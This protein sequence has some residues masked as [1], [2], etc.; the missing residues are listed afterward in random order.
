MLL[1]S[2][3]QKEI[4]T[5]HP[6]K[7]VEKMN[8]GE[9]LRSIDIKV[10]Q[11]LQKKDLASLVPLVLEYNSLA[12]KLDPRDPGFESLFC[13]IKNKVAEIYTEIS[14]QM[15]IPNAKLLAAL[16]YVQGKNFNRAGKISRFLL[17]Y[18]QKKG[19]DKFLDKDLILIVDLLSLQDPEQALK[20]LRSLR[21]TV[22]PQIKEIILD[23]IHLIKN[24]KGL[25]S[26][27]DS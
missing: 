2:D 6:F 5:S 22:D 13:E 23:T 10:Q 12:N 17:K 24:W 16:Y 21:K 8:T 19:P 15:Q 20:E 26:R 9:L 18:S 4:L 7:I 25:K 14:N 1:V 11:A 27:G 3:Y